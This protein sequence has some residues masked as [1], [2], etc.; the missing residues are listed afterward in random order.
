MRWA[1]SRRISVAA[2][3]GESRMHYLV[4]AVAA[5]SGILFGFDE[6]I[7][8]GAASALKREF[9]LT[10]FL[11]GLMTAAV[12]LGAVV[13]A[14][15]SGRLTGTYGRRRILIPVALLFI[16]GSALAAV[17]D[18]VWMLVG[19]RTLMGIAVGISS[20]A[21][22][23]YI[24]ETAPK[25][26][27]G[28][29]VSTF[30][31]AITVGILVAYLVNLMLAEDDDWR[32]MFALGIIP[33]VLLLAGLSRL[34]ESPRWLAQQ[35]R[36]D[37][38]ARAAMRLGGGRSA[39]GNAE[40]QVAAIRAALAA[41]PVGESL[42]TLFRRPMRATVIVAM[43]L[44]LL[45]QLSGINA[46]IYYAPQIFRATGFASEATELMATVGIGAINVA[47]TVVAMW[48]V[49]RLGRRRLLMVGFVGTAV[50]LAGL[51]LATVLGGGG[52]WSLIALGLFIA[53]FAV[54]LGPLP[55]VLMS[56]IF[57]LGMRGAGMSLASISNWGFN[58]MVVFSFPIL[59]AAIGLAGVFSIFAAMCCIGLIFAWRQVPET[60]GIS[61]EHI[62]RHL[63]S[64]APLS[65][66]RP[67]D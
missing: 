36:W 29:L 53:A 3:E 63:R 26:L 41:E 22:P 24:A 54:S 62:E 19:A 60:R 9:V 21:A 32:L 35:G 64:G 12:P 10:P 13:G 11:E 47:M 27:R 14:A 17:A 55:Y 7:I 58:F 8:A 33:A 37:D 57:P 18:S 56:E 25:N 50:S 16:L 2:A 38:A 44:F 65:R 20:M 48:L 52:P 51:V 43:C 42:A 61:L 28:R 6:G 49:E 46:V 23:L 1:V 15:V 39:E 34:P 31:L 5:I 40:A 67:E 59:L 66:L 30:Q 45:Q 4:A